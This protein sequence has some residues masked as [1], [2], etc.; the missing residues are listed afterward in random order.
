LDTSFDWLTSL[1]MLI[2]CL[3]IAC[4]G[5]FLLGLG[6]YCLGMSVKLQL[7]GRTAVGRVLR[8]ENQDETFVHDDRPRLS[9]LRFYTPLVEFKDDDG[10]SHV[11]KGTGLRKRRFSIGADVPV[12]FNPSRADQN[13]LD[14]ALDKWFIPVLLLGLSTILVTVPALVGSR[15]LNWW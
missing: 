7:V 9:T 8:Y 1:V 13:V 2:A 14:T 3:P 12:L 11:I 5:L 4:L 15:A 6:L 10:H